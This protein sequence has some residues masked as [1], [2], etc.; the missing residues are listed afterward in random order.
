VALPRIKSIVVALGLLSLA[1]CN[2]DNATPAG[3][4]GGTSQSST[5]GGT[6][7]SAGTAQLAWQIPTE[8]TNGTPLTDLAGY[9]IVY[10]TSPGVLD[11]SAQVTDIE[12]TSYV[13]T[14]LSQGTW[15]FAILSNTSSGE[16]SALSDIA[17]TTIS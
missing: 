12:T 10:G 5:G 4:Q 7:A 11:H 17:S 9:T 16:S 15:Y 3:V 14:G 6:S 8:N 2:F 13:V 1:G